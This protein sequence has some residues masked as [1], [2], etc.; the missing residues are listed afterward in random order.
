MTK[1]K[2]NGKTKH[3]AIR[4]PQKT[5]CELMCSGRVDTNLTDES[6]L[7]LKGDVQHLTASHVE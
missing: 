6:Y 4:I 7:M 3:R 1:R 5:V 2:K